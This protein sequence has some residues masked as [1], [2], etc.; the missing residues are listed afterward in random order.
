MH[1][2]HPACEAIITLKEYCFAKWFVPGILIVT[3]AI[4]GWQRIQKQRAK[5]S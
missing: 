3:T 2:T 1:L 5:V 4:L